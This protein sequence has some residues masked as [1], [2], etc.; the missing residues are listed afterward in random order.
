MIE[1]H[2]AQLGAS[3]WMR[4]AAGPAG[5]RFIV[6]ALAAP[7]VAPFVCPLA[8]PFARTSTTGSG[9]ATA[10]LAESCGASVPV[11]APLV[12]AEEEPAD[13]APEKL[14]AA[15]PAVERAGEE[16]PPAGEIRSF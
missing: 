15:S 6:I 1:P 4:K 3:S 10:A 9:D 14:G 12:P 13:A 7:F 5:P 11:E 16:F 8:W 2:S